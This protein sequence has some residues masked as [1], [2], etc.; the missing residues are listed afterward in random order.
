MQLDKVRVDEV[1]GCGGGLVWIVHY[2]SLASDR[3][4]IENWPEKDGGPQQ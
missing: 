2:S 3:V 1:S 4:H